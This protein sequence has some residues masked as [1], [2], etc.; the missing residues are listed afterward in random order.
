MIGAFALAATL[1]LA[2]EQRVAEL[3]AGATSFDERV[4]AVDG[5]RAILYRLSDQS[6]RA[7]PLDDPEKATTIVAGLSGNAYPIAAPPLVSWTSG[8]ET[9]IAPIDAPGRGTVFPRADLYSMQC[10]AK[11]CLATAQYELLLLRLDG[12]IYG[13]ESCGGTVLTSDPDGFLLLAA[14]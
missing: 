14:P 10:N 3:R 9:H 2:P 7:V 1:L 13:R 4:L 6:L 12:T 8:Q 11:A 5:N